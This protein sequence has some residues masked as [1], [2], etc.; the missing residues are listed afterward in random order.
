[1]SPPENTPSRPAINLPVPRADELVGTA[2]S[3]A[4]E[5]AMRTGRDLKAKKTDREIQKI[6]NDGAVQNHLHKIIVVGLYVVGLAAIAMF[7][8]LVW[9][10]VT[11]WEFLGPEKIADIKQFLFSGTIGAGLSGLAKKYLGFESKDED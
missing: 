1:M 3:A 6:L 4:E 7:L 5:M 8:V 2:D 9:H 11:P 10:F